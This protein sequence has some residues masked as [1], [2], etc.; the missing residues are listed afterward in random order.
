MRSHSLCAR[1]DEL[2]LNICMGNMI[3]LIEKRRSATKLSMGTLFNRS[4][5]FSL[6][7][8]EN[9]PI[10]RRWSNPLFPLTIFTFK[11]FRTKRW[12][13]NR[14]ARLKSSFADIDLT[15]LMRNCA[16]KFT[17]FMNFEAKKALWKQR[18]NE[19]RIWIKKSNISEAS[20]VRPRN[21]EF[22]EDKKFKYSLSTFSEIFHAR[23]RI[24]R[25]EC[26]ANVFD[27][28]YFVLHC[29]KGCNKLQYQF[30]GREKPLK[31]ATNEYICGFKIFIRFCGVFFMAI[32]MLLH[33]SSSI[34]IGNNSNTATK[35][36][37]IFSFVVKEWRNFVKQ[38]MTWDW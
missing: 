19:K 33:R 26:A 32:E 15:W 23:N 6:L 10:W 28:W 20:I 38:I 30:C 34:I 36:V 35:S 27:Y 3:N 11:L 22:F 4:I 9:E 21:N 13:G 24:G 16:M 12:C 14:R 18:F 29:T 1:L 7:P 8:I 5:R 2:I 37:H 31:C 17:L 25:L